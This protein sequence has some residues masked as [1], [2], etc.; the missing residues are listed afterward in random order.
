M[1][2]ATVVQLRA[3][4]PQVPE[5]GQ[6]RITPTAD[7]LTLAYDGVSTSSLARG[8]PATAVQAALRAIGAIGTSGVKVS[9]APGGPWLASFQGDLAQNAALLIGA[10]ASVEAATDALLLDCLG[11]AT[12]T[13]RQALRRQLADPIFDYA[14]W[15]QASTRIVVG[16]F[17]TYLRLP[18]HQAG[19]V[20]LVEYQTTSSPIAYATLPDAWVEEDGRLYRPGQWAP[21]ARY[22]VTAQWGYG[23]DVPAVVEQVTLELAVN[24]WR[25]R[26]KGG[27]TELVGAEGGGA[28]RVVAGLTKQQEMTIRNVADQLRVVVI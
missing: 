17:G 12:D 1:P 9:G 10:G 28:V 25:S 2:Y 6:Q 7:T 16:C 18:P 26:D 22:R 21:N 14:D 20:A 3:Y 4:L 23:P 13:V 8:A 5:Y 24:I 27:F 15:P 19:S 11:R